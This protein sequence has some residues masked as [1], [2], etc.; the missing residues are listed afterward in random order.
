MNLHQILLW[1]WTFLPGNYVDDQKATT[2]GNWWL[3]A[4]SWQWAR[5]CITSHAEFFG[6][7]LNHP[8]DSAPPQSR[9][10]AL[11]LLVFPKIKTTFEREKISDSGEYSGAADGS[12]EN[13][14]RSQGAY[15]EGELR[16]HCPMYNVSG[17]LYLLQYMSLFFPI[18]WLKTFWRDFVIM[19]KIDQK[20]SKP[21]NTF[22]NFRS[23]KAEKN[24]KIAGEQRL[25]TN[26]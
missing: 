21:R 10:G 2:M 4:L 7:I 19:N 16:G 9:F 17:I 8:C 14:V 22:L 13:C 5:S 26:N 15:F 6:Q 12:W 20:K 25:P 18:T 24:F 11:W 23:P 1:T 3:A